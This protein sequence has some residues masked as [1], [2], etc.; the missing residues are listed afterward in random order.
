[1]ADLKISDLNSAS[2]IASDDLLVISQDLGGG[3]YVSKKVQFSDATASI[4]KSSTN[5]VYVS[6]EGNDS[7]ADGS[8]TYP[9]LT[10]SSRQVSS[11]SNP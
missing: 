4:D 1:M 6:K 8:I 5:T 9:F 3:S 2:D 10:S 7:T 11:A